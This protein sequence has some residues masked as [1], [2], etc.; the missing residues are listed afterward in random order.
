MRIISFIIGV[1]SIFVPQAVL[2]QSHEHGNGIFHAFTLEAASATSQNNV[3][4]II[5][6]DGWIGGDY[7]KL[8]IKGEGE[9]DGGAWQSAELSALYSKNIATFWDLQI[10]LRH[11]FATELEKQKT[12]AAIGINGLAPYFFETEAH[13]FLGEDGK[14]SAR[15]R[16]SNEILITN[17]L[18]S[19][20]HIE[21]DFGQDQKAEIGLGLQTRYEF[22]RHFAP[23]IEWKYQTSM[24]QKKSEKNIVAFGIRFL[25]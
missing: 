2:A 25:F 16:Q 24:G 19:E 10:G 17:K 9:F 11:D 23:F 4:N 14:L 7:K 3:S 6:T 8:W 18:I 20:P 13:L 22:N 15:L 12:F 1:L 5:E 21:I